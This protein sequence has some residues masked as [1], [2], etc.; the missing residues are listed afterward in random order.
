M[1]TLLFKVEHGDWCAELQ[2]PAT[3][4]L[5]DLAHAI[6]DAVGF[7]SDH[8][9]GFY[10]NL[11]TPHRSKERYTLFADMGEEVDEG[12]LGVEHMPIDAV[13]KPG[14]KMLFLF[15]YGDDWRFSVTCMA[16]EET[17]AFKRPKILSI[18]GTPPE[19]YPD[20]EE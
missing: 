16:G 15:D 12:D 2:M 5:G 4:V 13:F 17:R 18:T 8:A 11:K 20:G 7:D 19:Q 14:R 1:N 10:D 3:Y 9:Y 6:L